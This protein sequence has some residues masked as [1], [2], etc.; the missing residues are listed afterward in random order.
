[1]AV[2]LRVDI[3][4]V[5]MLMIMMV[6]LIAIRRLDQKDLLNRAYLL[7]LVVVFF[8]LGIEAITCVINGRSELGYVLASQGL[9]VMLYAIAPLLSSLWYLLVRNFVTARKKVTQTMYLLI[10]VPVVI[11]GILSLLS[12]FFGFLFTINDQGIYSRGP[13]FFVTMIITYSYFMFSL[14]HLMYY[15][16]KIVLNEFILLVLFNI[17]PV[18]GA[19]FQALF[20]GVLLAWSSAAFSLVVVYI[21]LQERLVHLDIMTGAWTRRSFDYFM[22]KRLKQK[23][24]DPFGG[25]FFDIDQLKNINDR[26]GHAEGDI[27]II[28][29]I[30][31]IKGLLK[32]N[33]FIARLGGDEFI[34]ISDDGKQERLENLVKDIELSLRVLNENSKKTYTLSCSFGY[35]LYDTSFK[36]VDQF[37]RYIDHRMYEAKKR[38]EG[39]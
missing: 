23:T 6:F 11:N 34:I 33:E 10:F 17:I 8:Q 16:K 1:M 13:L 14:I 18:V 31:R 19:I 36:S 28:E 4:L 22:D 25:I 15:R 37:L 35:G 24:I 27:A 32:T 9:H 30:S 7:T 38:L 12:P 21:Y 20:Y 5:A 26:F 39:E 2:F 29:I 3:N